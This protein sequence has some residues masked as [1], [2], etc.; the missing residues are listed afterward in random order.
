MR[1]LAP[2]LELQHGALECTDFLFIVRLSMAFQFQ[3]A[4]SISPT[5][6]EHYNVGLSQIEILISL[7]LA[8]GLVF[9]LPGGEIGRRFSDKRVVLFGLALMIIGG[10]AMAFAATWEWQLAGRIIAGIGGVL[11][12]VVMSKMVTDWFA[13]KE[14]ATA[15][16][17]FVTSWP[18]GI[19]LCLLLLPP[20]TA[21]KGLVVGLLLPAAFCAL[22]FLLLA[23]TYPRA[24]RQPGTPVAKASWPH[25]LAIR[26]VIAAGCIWGLFN[27]AI[28]MIFGFGTAM[29]TERGWTLAAAGLATS[30]VLWIVSLTSPIAGLLADK[31]GK[32][33]ELML[34]GLALFG[35]ALLMATRTDAVIP[36]FVAMGFVAGLSV[37]PIMSLPA[38]VL[39][40]A[41]ACCWD[42]DLLHSILRLRCARSDRRRHSLKSRGNGG[43]RV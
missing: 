8:P 43:D 9:A 2:G 21:A 5:L 12:N 40:S 41:R 16:A 18:V 26:A 33:I 29:L 35:I 24:P 32:H 30:L 22:G 36:V 39:R 10:V 25:P 37:G 19:A 3:S 28:G 6:M 13:G 42:G 20:I 34:S 14:I 23:G 4:A 15:M 7:Y 31:T 11:L 1:P 27:A 17:I 38:R